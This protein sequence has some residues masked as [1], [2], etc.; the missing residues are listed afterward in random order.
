METHTNK[1]ITETVVFRKK[2]IPVGELKPNSSIKVEVECKHQR[3]LVRW[4]RRNSP[5]KECHREMGSYST[6][7][8]GR[9]ITWGDKISEAKKGVAFS[10][11]HKQALSKAHIGIPLSQAHI[12]AQNANRPVGEDHHNY[13]GRTD[14][15]KR[16]QK[17]ASSIR[18]NLRK[19]QACP[20]WLTKDQHKEIEEFYHQSKAITKET[21]IPHEVDHIHALQGETFC[22][23]HVPWNLQVIPATINNAKSNKHP[24]D[25]T[26]DLVPIY[27][28]NKV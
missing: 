10:K 4:Y 8:K 19:A 22:G 1:I 20:K 27:S 5:C 11:E 18:Y 7:K 15:F 6:C 13:K 12:D 16:A 21:N 14:E 25:L 17:T 2:E 3:R 24:D 23:L 28:S 26:L 9:V